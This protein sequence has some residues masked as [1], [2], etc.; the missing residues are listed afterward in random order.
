MEVI[1]VTATGKYH[2]LFEEPQ[3]HYYV[4]LSQH[5]TALRV[6]HVRTASVPESL[7]PAV[8]RIV[9]DLEPGL[10]VYDVQSMED[11]LD[12]GYGF[13]LARTASLFALVLGTLAA[14]LAMVGLYG[15]VSCVVTERSREIGIRLALGATAGRIARMVVT[16]SALLAGAGAA[17]GAVAAIVAARLMS[18]MLFGVSASDPVSFGAAAASLAVVT[19]IAASAPAARA[20]AMDPIAALR[21]E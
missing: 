15:V 4:P 2:L 3:P 5:Y 9:H 12:S 19:L 8:E 7:A 20:V 10:P 13:F 6:L 11:A 17:T 14:A 1:G 18:T 21:S 16:Q